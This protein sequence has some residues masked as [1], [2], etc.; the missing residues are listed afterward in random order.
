MSISHAESLDIICI[1]VSMF[2][3]TPFA[4]QLFDNLPPHVATTTITTTISM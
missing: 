4:M 1:P 3:L 2:C